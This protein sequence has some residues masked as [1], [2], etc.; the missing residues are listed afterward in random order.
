M[1][2]FR[3]SS[4]PSGREGGE[5]KG[6]GGLEKRRRL[7]DLSGFGQWRPLA[8]KRG[9]KWGEGDSLLDSGSKFFIGRTK[10][11][12]GKRKKKKK[13]FKLMI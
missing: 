12:G 8:K 2:I 3:P 1:S 10:G 5:E 7:L 13:P 6:G 4:I 11:E 9:K